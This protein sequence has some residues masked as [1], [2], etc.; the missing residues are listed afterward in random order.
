MRRKCLRME[1]TAEV[2]ARLGVSRQ[3][4]WNYRSTRTAQGKPEIRAALEAEGVKLPPPRR[5]ARRNRR[6][7]AR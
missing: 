6:G 2:A 7:G 4:V 1:G 5:R 3:T